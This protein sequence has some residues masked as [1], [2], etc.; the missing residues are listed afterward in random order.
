MT[1]GTLEDVDALEAADRSGMLRLLAGA[2]AQIRLAQRLAAEAGLEVALRRGMSVV[3]VGEPE[4]RLAQV[5]LQ[6]R[7]LHLPAPH[8][9][10][11]RTE[12]WARAV[13][14]LL[15]LRRLGLVRLADEA[16]EAAAVLLE[17]LAHRL[18]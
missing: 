7:S 8:T 10:P 5:A 4:G 11:V 14:V 16:I 9:G 17:D 3:T 12:L 15:V 2:A 6:S 13:P 1:L 18:R